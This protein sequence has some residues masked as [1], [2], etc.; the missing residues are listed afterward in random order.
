MR[1]ARNGD[2]SGPE[3]RRRGA[4]KQEPQDAHGIRDVDGAVC[5]RVE[6]IEFPGP[7]SR[8]HP[9]LA[10]EVIGIP[11]EEVSEEPERIGEVQ[12]AVLVGVGR[13]LQGREAVVL[14]PVLVRIAEPSVSSSPGCE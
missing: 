12:R 1:A 3:G 9:S 11:E 10:R 5:G 14:G 4:A 7:G 6:E 2:A 13:D 8:S